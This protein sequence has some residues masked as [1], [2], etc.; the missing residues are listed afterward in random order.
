MNVFVINGCFFHTQRRDKPKKI[1]NFGVTVEVEAKP[2]MDVDIIDLDYHS[3]CKVVEFSSDWINVNLHD[4]NEDKSHSFKFLK[5]N[6]LRRALRD[7][8]IF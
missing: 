5:Q 7:P 4:L 1:Q 6:I 2:V 3:E 8:Y